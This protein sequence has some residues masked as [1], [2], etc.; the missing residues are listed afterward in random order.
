MRIP[1]QGDCEGVSGIEDFTGYSVNACTGPESLFI[2]RA[3]ERTEPYPGLMSLPKFGKAPTRKRQ[4]VVLDP[5][6]RLWMLFIE[7]RINLSQ[8]ETLP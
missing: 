5:H 1:G 6:L 2:E 7:C 4:K 8:K 3:D